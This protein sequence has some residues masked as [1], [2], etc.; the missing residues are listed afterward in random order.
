MGEL[1]DVTRQVELIITGSASSKPQ[2]VFVALLL[3]GN[4][5]SKTQI[6]A[7]MVFTIR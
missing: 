6:T 7:M 2:H 1:F 4:E 3:S 5:D